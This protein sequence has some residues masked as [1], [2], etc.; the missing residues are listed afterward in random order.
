MKIGLPGYEWTG[1]ML[2]TWIEMRFGAKISLRTAQNL[3]HN[4][5]A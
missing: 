5:G 3:L 2:V 1:P 4:R